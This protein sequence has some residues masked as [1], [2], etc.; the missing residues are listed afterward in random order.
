MENLIFSL[1]TT[2]PI[3]L[4]MVLGYVLH[5]IG[6]MDDEFASKLNRFVFKV[7]PAVWRSGNGR[8]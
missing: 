1:N 2:V 5:E 3:F 8:L 7:P 4:M 6:W